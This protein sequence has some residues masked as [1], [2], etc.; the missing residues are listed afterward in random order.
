M[1]L[2]AVSLGDAGSI[3]LQPDG[4]STRSKASNERQYWVRKTAKI[5][6]RT[7]VIVWWRRYVEH[8][9]VLVRNQEL[10]NFLT[11]LVFWRRELMCWM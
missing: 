6:M 7:R 9:P 1:A 2:A 4:E 3:T 5:G 8:E 10:K 11:E